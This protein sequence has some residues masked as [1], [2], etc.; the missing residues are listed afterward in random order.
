MPGKCNSVFLVHT[1]SWLLAAF[2][3]LSPALWASLH[4]GGGRDAVCPVFFLPCWQPHGILAYSQGW[5]ETGSSSSVWIQ[6]G[7]GLRSGTSLGY[8]LAFPMTLEFLENLTLGKQKSH[9]TLRI[10]EVEGALCSF[11]VH[12][13]TSLPY[14]CPSTQPQFVLERP[15]ERTPYVFWLPISMPTES[16]LL[17][18]SILTLLFTAILCGGMVEG[19]NNVWFLKSFLDYLVCFETGSLV[20]QV[21]F[22][23]IM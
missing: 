20:V 11:V 14:R 8:S 15:W 7:K 22:K 10:S 6:N 4:L 12:L 16:L 23:V 5:L 21:G 13:C 18:S 19:G 1:V 9:L 3:A 17:E 2:C